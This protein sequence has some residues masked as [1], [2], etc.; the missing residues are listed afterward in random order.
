MTEYTTEYNANIILERIIGQPLQYGYMNQKFG[1][2]DF[3]FGDYIE[4]PGWNDKPRTV[5]PQTLHVICPFKVIWKNG[6]HRVDRYYEDTPS[7]TFH[8][9]V[10]CLV[11][12]CVK[13][14]ALSD[15]NDL[16]LDFGDYWVVFV[17]LENG[18]ESW[19]F[20]TPGS[21]LPHLVVSNSWLR[22]DY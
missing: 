18:E 15:K 21:S 2:Y 12:R 11:S 13:R 6:E 8:I 5:C 20:F 9:G 16:W 19:R 10:Q 3:G 14:V 1:L 17:T 7:E 4:I 22:L